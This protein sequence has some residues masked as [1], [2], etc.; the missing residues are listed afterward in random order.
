[1]S[2]GAW[3]VQ[4]LGLKVATCRKR[5]VGRVGAVVCEWKEGGSVGGPLL[6][7]IEGSERQ[8]SAK[9]MQPPGPHT[10]TQRAAVP[11]RTPLVV[12]HFF[13]NNKG[14]IRFFC[15]RIISAVSRG[16][17]GNPEARRSRTHSGD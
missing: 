10:R 9:K 2:L 1:M 4:G 7:V 15:Y 14:F 17:Q 12:E 8:K 11:P 16:T 5:R 6:Q 3:K 13:P